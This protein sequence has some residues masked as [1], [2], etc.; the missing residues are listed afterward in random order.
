LPEKFGSRQKQKGG[1][2]H[3][4]AFLFLASI[5]ATFLCLKQKPGDLILLS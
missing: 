2:F 1:A 5:L 4:P 3:G